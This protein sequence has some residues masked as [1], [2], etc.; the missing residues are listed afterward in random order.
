M[1]V[2]MSAATTQLTVI[3]DGNNIARAI[4]IHMLTN[5]LS[6]KQVFSNEG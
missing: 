1:S 5:V 3:A 4:W 6:K 2:K